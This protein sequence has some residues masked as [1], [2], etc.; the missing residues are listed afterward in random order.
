VEHAPSIELLGLNSYA[1]LPVVRRDMEASKFKGPFMVTEW[2]PNGHWEVALTSWGR[3]IEQS[4]A[5]KARTY[6]ERWRQIEAWQDRC[7]GSY[8]FIWG[9][10]QERT[11]TWY[12]LFVEERPELG[13]AGEATAQLD[14]LTSIWAGR[15]GTS[16]PEVWGVLL[17]GKKPEDNLI[18][19]SGQQLTAQALVAPAGLSG[20]RF[21]W[22]LLS[23]PTQL[24][25][26][27]G[28]EPRPPAVSEGLQP[29][30]PRATLRAPAPGEYRLFVYALGGQ[31]YVGTAN[32]PFKVE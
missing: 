9:Q 32:F 10:K 3:P 25:Q 13:L 11:P 4:S 24:G 2:G 8:V 14:A 7:L 30:G 31:G 12:G 15:E 17:A 20:L 26:A 16:A 23:E 29:D 22:E 1:G 18:V 6:V 28:Y 19:K 21:V 5:E 27:G